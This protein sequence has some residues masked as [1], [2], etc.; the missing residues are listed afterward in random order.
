MDGTS[1]GCGTLGISN[2]WGRT[3]STFGVC[4]DMLGIK[5]R[6]EGVGNESTYV[7]QFLPMMESSVRVF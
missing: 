7:E 1:C 2:Y 6:G 5:L 3:Y 4:V